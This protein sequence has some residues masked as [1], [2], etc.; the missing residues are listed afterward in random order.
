[1]EA[2]KKGYDPQDIVEVKLAENLAERVIG[3]ISAIAP[4][5]LESKA[6]ERIIELEKKYSPLDWRVAL[7][8]SLEIAQ[9]KFCKFKDEK[10]RWK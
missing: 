2:R 9:E 10:K 6:I 5:L 1:V 3:L 4:Q 7:Q 8:I